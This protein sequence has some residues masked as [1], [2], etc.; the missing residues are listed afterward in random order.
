MGVSFSGVA[1]LITLGGFNGSGI[2]SNVSFKLTF[3][4][5]AVRSGGR[6]VTGSGLVPVGY[7]VVKGGCGCRVRI[8]A[9]VRN[10]RCV[11]RCNFRFM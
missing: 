10:R 11:I 5:A 7:G 8:S 6:V 2:L 9:S 3:V 1:T 4:G